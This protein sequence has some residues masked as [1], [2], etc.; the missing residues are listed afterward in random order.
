MFEE[1]YPNNTIEQ[2]VVLTACEDGFVQEWQHDKDKM[3]EQL[4]SYS[5]N[6]QQIF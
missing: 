2:T 4:T 6:T 3:K 1:L 5:I